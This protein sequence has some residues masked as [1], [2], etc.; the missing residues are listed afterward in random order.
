MPDGKATGHEKLICLGIVAG[1]FGV[2][3]E[4][5]I[6]SFTHKPLSIGTYG[7]LLN[8]EG[9]GILSPKTVRMAQKFVIMRTN[10]IT[11]R[12]QAQALKSESLHVLR[13]VLPELTL[14][15]DEFY[16]VDLVGL[17]VFDTQNNR[18]GEVIGV[19]DFSGTSLLEIKPDTAA[20]TGTSFF[21]PF[22]KA[23]VPALNISAQHITIRL[24]HSDK[25]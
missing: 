16:H 25:E 4:L 13:A 14:Q 22:T 6:K 18:I 1:A 15:S 23:D 7:M 11:T 17:I 9:K 2:H 24:P 12:T 21:H 5:K 19:Y 10:E 8:A 3:G 20:K